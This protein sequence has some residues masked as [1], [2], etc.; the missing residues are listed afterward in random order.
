M[1]NFDEHTTV[2]VTGGA[3]FIGS[4]LVESLLKKGCQVRILDDLSTGKEKNLSSF[5]E[6]FEFFKGSLLDE[7]LLKKCLKNVDIVFHTAAIPSVPRSVKEPLPTSKINILGSLNV[8]ENA[9]MAKVKRLINSSSSSVYGD[10]DVLPKHEE[11][12]PQPLSPYAIAKLS[13]EYFGRVYSNLYHLEVFNLRYFNVFGPRQDPLSNYAAVIPLFIKAFLKNESPII[14]GDGEQTRDFTF[15]NDVV[16]ANLKAATAKTGIGDN[17]NIA[18][19]QKISINDL[20]KLIQ[21]IS[22]RNISAKNDPPRPGDILHS[23]ASIS[24]AKKHLDWQPT[25]SLEEGLKK[26][27]DWFSKHYAS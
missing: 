4:N 9:R 10:T 3:G 18:G 14:Y 12:P 15:V 8:L 17:F 24:K 20:V 23:H 6:K 2:L 26:T 1:T 7:N 16:Q 22:K 21:K 27:F 25:Y 19:G 13:I 11:M 5:S